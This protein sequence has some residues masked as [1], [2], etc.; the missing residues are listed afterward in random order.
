M[1]NGFSRS[2]PSCLPLN[3]FAPS[4]LPRDAAMLIGLTGSKFSWDVD[5]FAAS[6]FDAVA[7][8]AAVNLSTL[9]TEFGE[10]GC[11]ER[12]RAVML[13]QSCTFGRASKESKKIYSSILINDTLGMS[14]GDLD[15]DIGGPEYSCSEMA[16]RIEHSPTKFGKYQIVACNDDDIVTLN[17]RRIIASTGPFPIR[18]RD[19]CSIGARVFVFI[20]K[21]KPK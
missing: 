18:N 20:R 19:I 16:A 10:G 11:N 1:S 13:S 5:K 6:S 3:R 7:N 21:Y 9:L 14:L 12:F 2:L 17:G 4:S 15:C 8:Y